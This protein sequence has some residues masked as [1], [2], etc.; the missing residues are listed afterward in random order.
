LH[1]AKFAEELGDLMS[2]RLRS[3]LFIAEGVLPMEKKA[4]DSLR[5][6]GHWRFVDP[7]GYDD[8]DKLC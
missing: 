6:L 2:N 8:Q 1:E 3:I 4:H 7:E 5:E